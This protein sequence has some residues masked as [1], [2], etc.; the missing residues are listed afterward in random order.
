MDTNRRCGQMGIVYITGL[1]LYE[2]I[3]N[4]Y[5]IEL[6][7]CSVEMSIYILTTLYILT[8][9][10]SFVK[11]SIEPKKKIAGFLFS[12]EISYVCL[13]TLFESMKYIVFSI[14]Q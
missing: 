12:T 13:E 2:C 6:L 1:L 10:F 5:Y 3:F 14:V 9:S 4:A 11:K 8:T 7:F